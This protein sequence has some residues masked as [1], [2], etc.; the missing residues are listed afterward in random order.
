M[1]WRHLVLSSSIFFP[2]LENDEYIILT[3]VILQSNQVK[4]TP[5]EVKSWIR[6]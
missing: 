4:R 5:Q 3:C 1:I 6:W 2:I